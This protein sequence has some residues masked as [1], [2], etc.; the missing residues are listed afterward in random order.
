V[1]RTDVEAAR[2]ESWWGKAITVSPEQIFQN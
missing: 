1:T 2:Q